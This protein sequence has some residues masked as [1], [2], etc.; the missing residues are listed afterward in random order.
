MASY[1]NFQ[2]D[3]AKYT[4]KESRTDSSKADFSPQVDVVGFEK[5]SGFEGNLD[6]YYDLV[7]YYRF[8]PDLWYDLITPETGGIRL[9]ADQRVF[10][11]C[12][13][14][15]PQNYCTFPRG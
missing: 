13:A 4:K 3:N 9:D 10:L 8:Y 15:F 1:K 6:K 5:K 7:S 2:S 12:M 11:R 14:R